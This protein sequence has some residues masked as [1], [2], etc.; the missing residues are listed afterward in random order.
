MADTFTI[1][2]NRTGKSVEVPIEDGGI[3]SKA[4]RPIALLGDHRAAQLP[5][6][7]AARAAG[8]PL[9]NFSAASWNGIAVPAKTPKDIVARLNRELVRILALPEVKQKLADL[10][11]VAQS[12]TPEQQVELL[13]RDIK[14]WAGVIERAKI[15]KQ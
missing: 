13:D 14:R 1:I 9:A 8:G 4:L 5:E 15:P 12:S 10:T 11:L 2:D 7:P 6:V 3:S